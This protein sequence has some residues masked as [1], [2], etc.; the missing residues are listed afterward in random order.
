MADI[1]VATTG[2]DTTG[3]GSSGNP[4]ASPGKA[5][6]VHSGGDR[7]LVKAGTYSITSTSSNVAGGRLTL[8]GGTGLAPTIVQG[9][10]T[11]VGD[12]GQKPI[13]QASGIS[14]TTLITGASN[15]HVENITV[16]GAD[17]T[18]IRGMSGVDR[19]Y[20]CKAMRCKNSGFDAGV[21]YVLCEATGCSTAGG[22]F[23]VSAATLIGCYSHDNTVHGFTG[24]NTYVR[25][26][27]DTNTG[28]SA[29]G[30]NNGA[31][32]SRYVNCT[33]YNSGRA[34]FYKDGSGNHSEYYNCL[35]TNNGGFGFDTNN[36]S[37]NGVL[38]VNCAGY[39][40]TS[41]NVDGQ[42]LRSLGFVTLSA[43]PF[44]DA[45]GGNFAL[46]NTAGGGAACRAAGFPGAFPGGTT[47]G[48]L[49]IGAVQHQDSAGS[50]GG[51]TV[52]GSSIIRGLE[53]V[54]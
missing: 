31:A 36:S 34:G 41:G 9:Y 39:S 44:V 42:I 24:A 54:A 23:Q 1:Y 15:A 20:L 38:L 48:Y 8:T 25:C 3:D 30:F 51:G 35:A 53:R 13:L 40:N 37:D 47:T 32:A 27:A 14:S 50:G 21:Q 29:D 10:E 2:N 16:D 28:A 43:D 17:L 4:Y 6:S 46:N 52:I 11:T 26:V 33:S 45:A 12:F 5:G 7:I 19:A 18:S 49:D 22:G